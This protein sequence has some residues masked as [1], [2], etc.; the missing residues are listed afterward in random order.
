M[1]QNAYK[2]KKV[3]VTGHTGFKGAWLTIWLRMLGAEVRGYSIDIPTTP[4]LFEEIIDDIKINPFVSEDVCNYEQLEQAIKHFKPDI[5]FHLAAEAIVRNCYNNPRKAFE[6][7]VMGTVNVFDAAITNKI[8]AC[9]FI[10]SD[11][12]YE[13]IEWEYGY[14]ENDP[15]GGKDPY[16]ASKACAE[17]AFSAL[18]RSYTSGSDDMLTCTV[19]AGNVIGGGDWARD[20]IVPDAMRSFS[21]GKVLEIRSPQSTRPWQ[22]VLEPLSGYLQLGAELLNRNEKFRNQSFNFGPSPENVHSVAELLDEIKLHFEGTYNAIPQSALNHKE[23]GI[24][25]ICCDKAIHMMKWRSVLDLKETVNFTAQWYKSFYFNKK[26]SHNL[27]VN[28]INQYVAKAKER[29]LA[30]TRD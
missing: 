1:F 11:K 13:N 21:A 20:R 17:I 29:G 22:L 6:A 15:L 24:L 2:G 8:K 25:K 12:C 30:W 27:C 9:I 4:A 23:A 5:I 18:A 7:N 16:S 19:R 14:R 3:L 10:T 26:D 28:Q